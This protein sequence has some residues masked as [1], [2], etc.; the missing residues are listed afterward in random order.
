MRVRSSVVSPVGAQ[1][2]LLGGAVVPAVVTVI[3]SV[4]PIVIEKITNFERWDDAESRIKKLLLR[5]YLA[6]VT[7]S[8]LSVFSQSSPSR[9]SV[10]TQSSLRLLS[11][12]RRSVFSHSERDHA[13]RW[14]PR[15][16]PI[17]RDRAVRTP[18]DVRPSPD[19]KPSPARR[20]VPPPRHPLASTPSHR[21]LHTPPNTP[22]PS[23]DRRGC[24]GGGG[25][26]CG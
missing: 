14:P 22:A 16:R 8:L 9:L 25:C 15:H 6:K 23:P 1:A 26:G 4:S 20:A 7:L 21:R 12:S 3:N 11:V 10:F 17:V 13:G 18:S 24:G 2:E 5:M 19:A